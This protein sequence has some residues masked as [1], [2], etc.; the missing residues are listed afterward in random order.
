MDQ[1]NDESS[2]EKALVYL[3]TG[4]WGLLLGNK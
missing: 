1:L 2:N 3:S 4:T